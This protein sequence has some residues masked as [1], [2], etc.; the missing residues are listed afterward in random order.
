MYEYRTLTPREREKL[1]RDRLARGFPPHQPP[2]LMQGSGSYLVTA[3]CFEHHTYL[4]SPDRRQELLDLLFEKLILGGIQVV[5]WSVL[6]NH[7]HLLLETRALGVVGMV[8]RGVHGRTSR[9]WNLQDGVQGRK[10]WFRYT[11][12]AIRSERHYYTTLNYIHYNPVKHGLVESPYDWPWSSVCW[13]A[14]HRG[15]EWL[16]DAWV[17]YPVLDYGRGW[18]EL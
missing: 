16:R 4:R 14:E 1:V 17:Q 3:A 6:T 5:A 15:R 18:D 2:H 8:L 7:Y 12:R 13:Y 11:D 10:V 9:S